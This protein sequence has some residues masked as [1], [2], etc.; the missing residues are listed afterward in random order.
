MCTA[1]VIFIYIW[2]PSTPTWALALTSYLQGLALGPLLSG[3]S[4]IATSHA[5]LTDLND[6]STSYYFVRQL[7]NTFGVTAATVMFD[8]RQTLHSARLVDVANAL[9]PTTQATLAQYAGLIARNGGAGSNPALGAVQLLQS[10]VI[11]QSKLLSYIDIYFG[12]GVLAFAILCL[13][14]LARTKSA[15]PQ[16]QHHFH[17]W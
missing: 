4:N 17:L 2:T 3:A 1:S 7:G 13:L 15:S 14:F 11:T 12:L 10:G 6:V 8:H 9:D 5:T 16:S